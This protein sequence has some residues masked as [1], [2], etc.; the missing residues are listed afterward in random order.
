MFTKKNDYGKINFRK[1]QIIFKKYVYFS[2]KIEKG[3]DFKMKRK[4]VFFLVLITAF[5]L[6]IMFINN[7]KVINDKAN[8]KFETLEA[9]TQATA[10]DNIASGTSGTCSWLIDKDGKLIIWP[11]NDTNGT[12]GNITSLTGAPWYEKRENI[13]KVEFLNGVKADTSSC[14]ALFYNCTNLKM[15][16]LVILIHQMHK[17]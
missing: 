8:V 10:T 7:R 5:I 17:I 11:T 2:Y 6:A 12:L 9:P 16:I 14:K 15:W 3:I 4:I 13:K 1:A